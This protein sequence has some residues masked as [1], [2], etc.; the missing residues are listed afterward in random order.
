MTD[1][2]TGLTMGGDVQGRWGT[3]DDS[4]WTPPVRLNTILVS[5]GTGRSLR[6]L[7]LG[8]DDSRPG[9]PEKYPFPNSLNESRN[10]SNQYR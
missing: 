2:P 9:L 5:C 10:L 8:G 3:L 7:G 6:C 4:V 1:T